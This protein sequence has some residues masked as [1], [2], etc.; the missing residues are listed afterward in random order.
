MPKRKS[1][2]FDW[3]TPKSRR[4]NPWGSTKKR[5]DDVFDWGTPKG[6]SSNPWRVSSPKRRSKRLDPLSK[7]LVGLL[8]PDSPTNLIT[9]LAQASSDNPI[10]SEGFDTSDF[11]VGIFALVAVSSLVCVFVA[12]SYSLLICGISGLGLVFLA[13]LIFLAL[14][15]Q[16][17]ERE[18]RMAAQAAIAKESRAALV[19]A[20]TAM[21]HAIPGGLDE[22]T[23][24]DENQLEYL[25][26]LVY[27]RL[28]YL[29]VMR[30]GG[31]GDQGIDVWTRSPEGEPLPVQC[32]QYANRVTTSAVRDFYQAMRRKQA[33]RGL[34]WAP[35][36][37]SVPAAEYAEKHNV[38]CL[39]GEAIMDLVRQAY[40]PKQSP[41]L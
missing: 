29:D 9:T 26:T 32:K 28:G 8:R 20:T 27:Q 36:G 17:A 33:A 10:K 35:N 38:I 21:P 2:L 4:S 16:R 12:P 40:A 13:V 34:F 25:A 24:L 41:Q 14:K 39:D 7:A 22:L 6:R 23:D 15:E 11:L 3:G 1:D 18:Q 5:K 31:S 30:V 37:F 19:A